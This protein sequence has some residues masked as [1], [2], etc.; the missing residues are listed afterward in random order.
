[1]IPDLHSY[2][3]Y[4]ERLMVPADVWRKET[5]T[6]AGG[7][8][9]VGWVDQERTVPVQLVSPTAQERQAAAQ[10]GVEITHMAVMPTDVEVVRGDRLLP[11]GRT[12]PVELESDP[13]TATHSAVS[14]ARA[15]EEPWDE[16][17]E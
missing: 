13:I 9:T 10:E 11:E 17:T 5:T 4:A 14:R 1:M 6:D 8:Q 2:G 15:R 16:P 7:G 3:A 12:V